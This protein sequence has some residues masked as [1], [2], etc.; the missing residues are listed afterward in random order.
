MVGSYVALAEVLAAS[1]NAF[2]NSAEAKYVTA[3]NTVSVIELTL[4]DLVASFGYDAGFLSDAADFKGLLGLILLQCQVAIDP[5]VTAADQTKAANWAKGNSTDAVVLAK[6][7]HKTAQNVRDDIASDART[8]A[9]ELRAANIKAKAAQ[10]A[11]EALSS[12]LTNPN[13]KDEVKVQIINEVIKIKKTE[14]N[15]KQSRTNRK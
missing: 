11:V 5:T 12:R 7:L 1:V 8:A 9:R 4:N 3:K 13:A 10:T 6:V 2:Y 14:E 15:R